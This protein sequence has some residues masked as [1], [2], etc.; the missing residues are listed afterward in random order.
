MKK[1]LK[2]EIIWPIITFVLLFF[3]HLPIITKHLLT[4][5]IILNNAVYKGYSWEIS[6]GRFGLYL[7]GILKGFKT[8]PIIEYLL[9]CLFISLSLLLWNRIFEVKSN[10]E[11]CIMVLLIV[12]SPMI[13]ATLLFYY[14]STPYTFSLFCS[15]YALYAFIFYK[16]KVFKYLLPVILIMLALSTYQAY[17]SV[18]VSIYAFYLLKKL[19]DKEKIKKYLSYIFIIIGGVLL[20]YV[21]MKISLIVFNVSMSEYQNANSIGFSAILKIKDNFLLTYQLFYKYFFSD[22]VIK[23]SYF[24]NSYL[25]LG[26]LILFV[27]EI[28]LNIKKSKIPKN[29][30]LLIILIIVL[31]PCFLNAITFILSD[32]KLQLL[33]SISY[34]MFVM[35]IGTN[36]NSNYGKYILVILVTFLSIN[37]FIEDQASYKSIEKTNMAYKDIINSSGLEK[38]KYYVI[39]GDIDNRGDIYKKNYGFVCD[40]GIFWEEYHLR[41]LGFERYTKQVFNKKLNFGSEEDYQKYQDASLDEVLTTKDNLI[42]IDLRQIKN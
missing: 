19:L 32:S 21:V 22:Y 33:M 11:K 8:I 36:T 17:L 35:F 38:D 3:L 26:L 40:E 20:Y 18:A 31:L 28:V 16:K 13:S 29:S 4:A 12:L 25:Y 2:K 30:I 6:L 42:I 27:V 5:D 39:V 37:Y 14:C 10:L 23:N 24:H 1:Y 41:K 9:S 15:V 7:F 34:L